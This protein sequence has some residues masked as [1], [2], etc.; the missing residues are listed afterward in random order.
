[1]IVGFVYSR[2]RRL[3]GDA[4]GGS[5]RA[6]RHIVGESFV[7]SGLDKGFWLLEQREPD[8]HL[9]DA[10]KN[11]MAGVTAHARCKHAGP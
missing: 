1:M 8:T 5:G 2:K 9:I 6:Q 7:A 4:M 10:N 3:V 11:A